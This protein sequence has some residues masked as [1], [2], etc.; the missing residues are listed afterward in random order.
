MKFYQA[1]S[2]RWDRWRQELEFLSMIDKYR[3]LK[4]FAIPEMRKT[5]GLANKRI[6][7][8][9]KP[10]LADIQRGYDGCS[11]WLGLEKLPGD[12]PWEFLRGIGVPKSWAINSSSLKYYDGIIRTDFSPVVDLLKSGNMPFS[13]KTNKRSTERGIEWRIEISQCFN[14]NII[15]REL[16]KIMNNLFQEIFEELLAAQKYVK[17]VDGTKTVFDF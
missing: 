12:D 1:M 15:V 8:V 3:F 16:T 13:F 14:Q 9:W 11:V 5:L 4:Y 2:E 17:H 10:T 6:P 7:T